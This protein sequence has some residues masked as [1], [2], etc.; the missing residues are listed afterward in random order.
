[1]VAGDRRRQLI[2]RPSWLDAKNNNFLTIVGRLA[3]GIS[4]QQAAAA[5]TPVSIQIDMER[6]GPPASERDRRRLFESKLELEFAGKGNLLSTQPVLEAV[7]RGVLDGSDGAL[8]GMRERHDSRLR[9][10][11]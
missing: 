6:N 5:L 3:Q 8:A 7:A 2:S 1:M 4:L 10:C 11:R 9:A